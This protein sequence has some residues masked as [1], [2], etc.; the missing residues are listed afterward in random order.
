MNTRVDEAKVKEQAR[1][2]LDK[3]ARALEKV[4]KEE[5]S[6]S[7]VDREEFMREE[8]KGEDSVS[9]F[10]E[11]MLENSPRHDDDFIIAEK[12]EWK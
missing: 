5:L 2:I 7:F 1:E 8:G 11:K 6:E 4:E 12:G 9:G 10:K 3:F